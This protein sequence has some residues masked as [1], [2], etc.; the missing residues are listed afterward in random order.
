MFQLKC[1]AEKENPHLLYLFIFF[2]SLGQ[3]NGTSHH[4][5]GCAC[6]G[7]CGW[8]FTLLSLPFQILM[9]SAP[10]S[11]EIPKILFNIFELL[12]VYSK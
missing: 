11:T 2:G 6:G 10:S 8:G 3:L 4:G 7:G 12:L 1:W 5:W 9:C